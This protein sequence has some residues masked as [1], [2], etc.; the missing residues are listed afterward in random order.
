[1]FKTEEKTEFWA[2]VYLIDEHPPFHP[3]LKKSGPP[4][5]KGGLADVPYVYPFYGWFD[6]PLR[7]DATNFFIMKTLD[8]FKFVFFKRFQY[9]ALILTRNRNYS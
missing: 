5:F 3:P 2:K 7:V 1:M 4:F 8:D 6:P 9:L